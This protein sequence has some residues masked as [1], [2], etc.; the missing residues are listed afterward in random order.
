MAILAKL[1][2]AIV[3]S[4]SAPVT[5]A[6]PTLHNDQPP[7]RF[8]AQENPGHDDLVR[9][10]QQ[11]LPAP[12]GY[13]LPWPGGLTRELTQGENTFFT[14]N[15]TTAFAYDFGLT[16]EPVAASRAGVVTM[17]RSDQTAG[18]CSEAFVGGGNYVVI[19]HRDGTSAL[20]L[21][22]DYLGVLV[23]PGDVVER[24]QI[25]GISGATGLTCSEAGNGP[26]PH[27]HFQVEKTDPGQYLTQSLPIRFEDVPG[28]GVPG[29]LSSYTSGNYPGIPMSEEALALL[30]AGR[31]YAVPI[32]PEPAPEPFLSDQQ[33]AAE[34]APPPP[35]GGPPAVDTPV[36]VTTDTNVEATLSPTQ[37]PPPQPATATPVP[38]TA[39]PTDTPVPPTPTSTPTPQPPTATDT[40]L[41]VPS[42]TPVAFVSQP[43]ASATP[44]PTPTATPTP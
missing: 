16:Y 38:P 39:V 28:D 37:T 42:D 15:G 25:I 34:P 21:H 19:D 24:G 31:P 9:R 8:V 11:G 18:G 14:H 13:R 2:L 32:Y 43:T 3:A 41:P 22:L 1:L 26:G 4:L 27:L 30:R 6:L 12:D 44:S 33:A 35:D 17:V 40:P 5:V 29:E 23:K 7:V 36:D 10:F 20:Y